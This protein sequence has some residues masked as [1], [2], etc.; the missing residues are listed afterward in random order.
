[1]SLV[2]ACSQRLSRCGTVVAITSGVLWIEDRGG[3]MVEVRPEEPWEEK[4]VKMGGVFCIHHLLPRVRGG[5]RVSYWWLSTS[6][7]T[8]IL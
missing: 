7:T 6:W 2:L 8:L 1:M 5:T 3:R 4:A